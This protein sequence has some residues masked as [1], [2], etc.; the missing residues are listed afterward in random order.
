MEIEEEFRKR[1]NNIM[2]FVENTIIIAGVILLNIFAMYAVYN[3]DGIIS[4]ICEIYF[5]TIWA[6]FLL[7][8]LL[9]FSYGVSY[10]ILDS[11]CETKGNDAEYCEV[12]K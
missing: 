6:L 9:G 2:L 5:K 8:I 11:V 12:I 3:L 10:C 4:D 1:L 7:G